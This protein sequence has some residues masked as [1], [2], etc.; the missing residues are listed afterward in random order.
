[1][2]FRPTLDSAGHQM[3]IDRMTESGLIFAAI[4]TR[5]RFSFDRAFDKLPVGSLHGKRMHL[6][7]IGNLRNKQYNILPNWMLHLQKRFGSSKSNARSICPIMCSSA[8]CPQL[9]ISCFYGEL[10]CPKFN[11]LFNILKLTLRIKN[12]QT[13]PKPKPIW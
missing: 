12:C 5:G 3:N 8:M 10:Y 4:A 13:V 2:D 6:Y 9:S 7:V 11:G 1:M